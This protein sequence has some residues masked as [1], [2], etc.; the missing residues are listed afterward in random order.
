MQANSSM[1]G[2]V[3]STC[4]FVSKKDTYTGVFEPDPEEVEAWRQEPDTTYDGCW[5]YVNLGPM[6]VKRKLA[7]EQDPEERQA[8]MKACEFWGANGGYS[9]Q[10]EAGTVD[11]GEPRQARHVKS[12]R[13]AVGS[14]RVQHITT[15]GMLSVD[16]PSSSA[17]GG[18]FLGLD[19]IDYD[20]LLDQMSTAG[21]PEGEWFE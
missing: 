11:R 4:E 15:R 21:L 10:F 1:L 9:S 8:L 2:L 14:E 6:E 3:R 16:M 20:L 13:E 18:R 12:M 5:R 17:S 7:I 19:V